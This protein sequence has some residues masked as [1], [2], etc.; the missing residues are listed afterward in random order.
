MATPRDQPSNV[1]TEDAPRPPDKAV[2]TS[3]TPQEVI[4][5][6]AAGPGKK[7]TAADG[8]PSGSKDP[9]SVPD[10]DD[11][12]K[13]P[14]DRKSE[15]RIGK[16][17]KRLAASD[18]TNQQNIGRIAELE[19]QVETLKA[20]KPRAPEPKLDDF[21]S[22]AEYAKAWSTWDK[23]GEPAK[24]AAKPASPPPPPPP[25]APP[26]DTDI[27][28]WI[29]AGKAELGDEFVEALQDKD[30][31]INTTMGEFVMDSDQG[32]KIY[33]HL[34]NNPKDARKIFDSKPHLAVKAL[35]ALE[36]KAKAGELDVGEGTLD[37]EDPGAA[38]DPDNDP[39]KT[40]AKAKRPGNTKAPE[41]PKDTKPGSAT[42]A[43]SPEDE[44]MEEYA[45][46]RQREE[47]KA[48][49]LPPL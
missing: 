47:R 2:V 36:V 6:R 11:N 23:A 24:P 18:A 30:N 45:A 14:R 38:D 25:A 19:G 8:Q 7:K 46:R 29:T 15:R 48:Q 35:E 44:D 21:K 13:P 4:E 43:K 12:Q 42:P 31:A 1:A 3:D 39:K 41:P 27:S 40:P 16:L 37:I 10:N 5:S 20:A 34:S 32:H 26:Q 33:V 49:G 9:D 17:S 28:E 22:P